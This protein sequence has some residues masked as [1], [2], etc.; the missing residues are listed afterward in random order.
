MIPIL[1]RQINKLISNH[2]STENLEV[3]LKDIDINGRKIGC[4]GFIVSGTTGSCVYLTTEPCSNL[5]YMYRYADDIK[6]FEGYSNHWSR[7]VEDLVANI[8][9]MLKKTPVQA[10]EVRI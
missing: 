4:S 2:K 9:E 10:G 1:A 8:L 3:R 7:T 5:G 6:D